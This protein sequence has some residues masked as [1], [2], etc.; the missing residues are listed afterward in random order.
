MLVHVVENEVEPAWRLLHQIQRVSS[1][2]P[3]TFRNTRFAEIGFG[4]P[5]VFRIAIGIENL[6]FWSSG[7]RQPDG[8]IAD[9]GAHFKNALS[10]GGFYQE[11]KQA[12]DGGADDRH[13]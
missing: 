5:G 7:A 3:D 9:G 1:L 11:C 13:V 8:G 10:A 6:C 12:S 2:H 4:A